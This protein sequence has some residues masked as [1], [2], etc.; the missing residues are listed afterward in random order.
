MLRLPN[1]ARRHH[2]SPL[3]LHPETSPPPVHR[4]AIARRP[5][6]RTGRARGNRTPSERRDARRAR[7]DYDHLG[8]GLGQVGQGIGLQVLRLWAK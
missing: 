2:P 4:R 3:V 7:A 5:R 6:H 1:L 8:R